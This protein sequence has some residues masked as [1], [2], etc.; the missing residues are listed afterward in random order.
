MITT[1]LKMCFESLVDISLLY[2]GPNHTYIH[3]RMTSIS[4][5]SITHT[6]HALQCQFQ[7][8]IY[9]LTMHFSTCYC[10]RDIL[11]ANII[12]LSRNNSNSDT[13]WDIH[14][15][16]CLP[17]NRLFRQESIISNTVISEKLISG[18]ARIFTNYSSTK[19]D[20]S[21]VKYPL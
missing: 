2:L 7:I 21:R 8:Y 9:V 4:R 3:S 6:F 11:N 5:E 19:Y 16:S 15:P 1:L 13:S 20:F 17:W 14:I 12:A 10:S 18:F